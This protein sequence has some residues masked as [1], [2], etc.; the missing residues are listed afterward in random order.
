[1]SARKGLSGLAEGR[2]YKL[3]LCVSAHVVLQEEGLQV[4]CQVSMGLL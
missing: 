2:N 4:V 3:E 1:M